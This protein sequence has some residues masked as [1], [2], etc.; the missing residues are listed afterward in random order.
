MGPNGVALDRRGNVY[1][2]DADNNA[3][4]RGIPLPVCATSVLTGNT[5]TLGWSAAVGQLLQMQTTS[6]L[7]QANWTNWGD[8][9][10]CSNSTV[11][12]QD[13]AASDAQRFYRLLVTP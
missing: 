13:P 11:T 2:A 9:F 3:I 12:L 1:V 8:P 7:A 4:R 6:D 10:V 5:L